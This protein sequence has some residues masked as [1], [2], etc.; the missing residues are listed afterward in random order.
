MLFPILIKF[1][2]PVVSQYISGHFDTTVG[3]KIESESYSKIADAVDMKPSRILFI[4]DVVKGM[5]STNS[6]I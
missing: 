5:Y 2:P 6:N 4:T 1:C 3:A